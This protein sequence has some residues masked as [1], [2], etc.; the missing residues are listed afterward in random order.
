HQY[1]GH[2]SLAYDEVKYK[3]M[4]GAGPFWLRDGG[5]VSER[6]CAAATAFQIIQMTRPNFMRD[7]LA[8]YFARINSQPSW[9]PNRGDIVSMWEQ[10]API[11]NGASFRNWLNSQPVFNGKI[12]DPG[13]Y[14]F[15]VDRVYGY[16]SEQHVALSYAAPPTIESRMGDFWSVFDEDAYLL[17]PW[18]PLF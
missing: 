2:N 3:R 13:L 7:F 15:G 14:I 16:Q 10:L 18:L 17:P 4:L 5:M 6:Y 8:I 12:L 9:R 11:V 1:W